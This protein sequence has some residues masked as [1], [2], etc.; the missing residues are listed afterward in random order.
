MQLLDLNYRYEFMITIV[1]DG[2]KLEGMYKELGPSHALGRKYVTL[3]K[4][5]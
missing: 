1:V 2:Y 3:L 4:G 5:L